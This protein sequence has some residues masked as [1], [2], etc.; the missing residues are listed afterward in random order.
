MNKIT[1]TIMNK[2]STKKSPTFSKFIKEKYF[3]VA[4]SP[5]KMR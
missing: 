3:L 5:K 2:K 1:I 4:A